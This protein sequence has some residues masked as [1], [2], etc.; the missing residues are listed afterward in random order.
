MHVE[1]GVGTK[2]AG[3]GSRTIPFQM[4]SGGVLRVDNV[5]WVPKI[6]KSVLSVSTIENKGF[7]IIFQDGR[8]LIKLRGSSLVAVAILGVREGNFYRLNC[9]PM[10]AMHN[11]RVIENKDQKNS[12]VEKLR[13]SQP[14]GSKGKENLSKKV[15]WYEMAIHDA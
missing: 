15:S 1:L 10:R 7:D 6:K 8:V 14:S 9:K 4:E 3:E 13:G 2:Y 5:L 12:K 11:T